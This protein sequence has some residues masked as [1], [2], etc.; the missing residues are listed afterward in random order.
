MDAAAPR[1]GR[2]IATD[3][4]P[5]RAAAPAVVQPDPPAVD[6][7]DFGLLSSAEGWVLLGPDLY[8]TDSGGRG[9]RNISP[10]D[11]AGSIVIAAF[12]LDARRGWAVTQDAEGAGTGDYALARTLD[13]GATWESTP[14]HLFP[15]EPPVAPASAVTL[16]FVD[17]AAG[18]LVVR[19]A[20]SSN[21]SLGSLFA[22]SD[23]GRTWTPL[24]IPIG[25]PVAFASRDDGWTAGGA[26]GDELY[27]TVDGGRTWQAQHV[28]AE[29]DRPRFYR[30]PAFR[31]EREG[32]L[33]V[34]AADDPARLELYA[35]GDGGA[36]WELAGALPSG[37]GAPPAHGPPV[38]LIPGERLAAVVAE[39]GRLVT[40]SVG[41]EI[42]TRAIAGNDAGEITRLEM[43]TLSSGWA[44]RSSGSCVRGLPSTDGAESEPDCRSETNLLATSDGGQTWTRLELPRPGAAVGVSSGA[45]T[46]AGQAPP[47]GVPPAGSRNMSQPQGN[48]TAVFVGQGFDTCEIPG[49]AQL[50]TWLVQSPYRAV[51]LY[52]GGGARAC[53]NRALTASLLTELDRSGWKFIPTWVG[54]Q[55]PC[56]A[57]VGLRMS[58]DPAVARAQGV[59]EANA[60]SAAAAGLGLA[61]PD[62]SGAILYYDMEY[63]NTADAACHAAVKA[64]VSG[65]SAQLHARGS[66][67]GVYATGSPLKSFTAL[68]DVPDAIWAAHWI[69]SSYNKDATVWD[70][71]NLSND[72][73]NDHQRIRQYTGGHVET[74]GGVSL[75]IDCDVIDGIVARAAPQGPRFNVYLPV[76]LA[77]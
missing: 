62:G 55:A 43:A 63:Y 31:D 58:S 13:G 74:W 33:P 54:P 7:R 57:S 71:Y 21:F 15:P 20:S 29:S 36:T 67:A 39:D 69:K 73:W 3:A 8:R 61:E 6:V 51:N 17:D 65:W 64:F 56:Q 49:R 44:L 41:G 48:R 28:G 30:L 75:N 24:T 70:V 5:A 32:L 72:L 12:F 40:A 53:S 27:R 59:N 38:A 77:F 10:V 35:T 19:H 22:T 60:A 37:G 18:W 47:E 46:T 76:A 9:W 23:G 11:R 68:S 4:A 25:E 45:A 34:I 14:L 50:A 52:I 2:G 66:L 42:T 16:H 26:A 1:E